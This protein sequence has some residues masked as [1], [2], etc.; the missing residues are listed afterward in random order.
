MTTKPIQFEKSIAELQAIVV[1]LEKGELPLEDSLEQFEKGIHIARK[2]QEIL[3]Q[4]EQKIE[5]LSAAK[6]P[7]EERPDADD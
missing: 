4:A 6:S 2:C 5:I 7:M 1:Q 3:N